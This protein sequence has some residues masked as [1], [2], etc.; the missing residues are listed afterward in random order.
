MA[1][2]LQ[3]MIAASLAVASLRMRRVKARAS[4]LVA[5]DGKGHKAVSLVGRASDA[6]A[7]SERELDGD[8]V[9]F[10]GERRVTRARVGWRSATRSGSWTTRMWAR[11]SASCGI[12]TTAAS[13]RGSK[14]FLVAGLMNETGDVHPRN[15]TRSAR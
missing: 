2:R 7:P 4:D 6:C 3:C 11:S 14:R 12:T 5:D 1:K 13:R 15:V 10:F 9:K 8:C